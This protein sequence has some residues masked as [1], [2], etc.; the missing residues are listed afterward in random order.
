MALELE[1]PHEP[2]AA[3]ASDRVL[4]SGN[5]LCDLPASRVRRVL[6]QVR[7]TAGSKRSRTLGVLKPPQRKVSCDVADGRRQ[8]AD[9]MQHTPYLA[10]R[11]RSA[12]VRLPLPGCAAGA[13]GGLR[14]G[15]LRAFQAA[16]GWA[17]SARYMISCQ[18][19]HTARICRPQHPVRTSSTAWWQP[20]PRGGASCHVRTLR[21]SE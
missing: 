16:C 1:L 17:V 15:G 9:S 7:G 21:L 13:A 20:G 3:P 12:L 5:L 2:P 8:T 14:G 4:P 18:G 10:A 19:S 11:R 6:Q